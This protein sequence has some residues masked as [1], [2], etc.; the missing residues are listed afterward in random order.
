MKTTRRRFLAGSVAATSVFSFCSTIPSF[1]RQA[2]AGEG[3]GGERILVV[4][5]LS[6]GNDGLNTVVPFKHPTYRGVRPTLAIGQD[7]VLRINDELGLHPSLT[8]FQDLLENDRLAIVQG[9]G[10]PDPNRSH[11]ESMDIWHTCQRKME[12]RN[13]GWLGRYVGNEAQSAVESDGSGTEG[14]M[15]AL[16]LGREQQPL[17]LSS[18]KVRVPSIKSL[19]QFRLQGSTSESVRASIE[20][21]VRGQPRGDD[22]LLDFVASSTRSAFKA[23]KQLEE[24]TRGKQSGTLYPSTPLSEKLKIVASLIDSPLDTRIYYVTIDGFD[25]HGQQA[26]AHASLLGQLD[27]AVSAFFED[28]TSRGQTNRVMMMCFSEFGRRLNENASKGTDH[29]AAA[30]MFLLGD[31][32]KPGLH[33]EHPSMTDLDQ[34]DLKHHTDFRQVYATVLERWMKTESEPVLGSSFPLLPL[35]REQA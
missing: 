23:S 7:Q 11:F 8:G 19:D 13:E 22:S 30:P 24:S 26:G 9:V 1:L 10:Y 32:V 27:G 31:N 16:H 12:Q 18:E 5:Q 17:A 20:S 29:G 25:T 3:A 35:F 33:G 2:V 4:V 15:P 21:L 14:R 6:G 28:L 34:G